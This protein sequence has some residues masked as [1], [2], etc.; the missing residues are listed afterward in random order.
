MSDE[1]TKHGHSGN[2]DFER[3][4]L[5]A[6]SIFDFLIGLAIVCAIV[7]FIL[8][9]MYAYLDAREKSNQP[10]QNPLVAARPEM[11]QPTTAETKGEIKKVFPEPRLE[12]DERGELNGIRL[13]E[14]RT[15]NSYGWVDEKAGVVHIP[16]EQA[17][18]LLVSRGLPTRPQKDA[19]AAHGQN[20][21][22]TRQ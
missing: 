2:A 22:T 12:D 19:A 5:G 3:E 20:Q 9:G 18:K 7:Y 4:D 11:G 16:I 14:E 1:T 6:K 21:T 8:R 17:M 15:L 13:E 10:P